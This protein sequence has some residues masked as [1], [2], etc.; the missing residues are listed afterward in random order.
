MAR[1]TG[2]VGDK[3]MYAHGFLACGRNISV[4]RKSKRFYILG[5][6]GT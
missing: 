1:L 6:V 2:K 5:L 3:G 4:E